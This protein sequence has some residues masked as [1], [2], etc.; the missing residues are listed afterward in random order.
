MLSKIIPAA[1][2]AL[3]SISSVSGSGFADQKDREA[4]LKLALDELYVI[5][6]VSAVAVPVTR[7][8]VPTIEAASNRRDSKVSTRTRRNVFVELR[9]F[10]F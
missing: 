4:Q 3:I 1:L 5:V 6:I 8:C 7:S 2:L 10:M 9:V